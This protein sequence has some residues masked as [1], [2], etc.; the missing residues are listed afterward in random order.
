M[1]VVVIEP[2]RI[3]IR[4]VHFCLKVRW[5]DVALLSTGEGQKGLEVIE[6]ETPDLVILSSHLPDTD[7][8]DLIANIRRFSQVPLIV[9]TQ[10]QSDMDRV[11]FLEA[12]ADDCITT[13][14]S[15]IELLTKVRVLLR[16]TWGQ[17]F[18]FREQQPITIGDRVT[19]NTGTREV[20]VSDK[21]VRLTPT[22]FRVLLELVK[23]QGRVVSNEMLLERAWGAD[24]VSDVGF[25]KRYVYR[26]RQK[27]E[28]GTNKPIIISERGIGYRLLQSD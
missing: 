13:P 16:R 25:V 1:K 17:G 3:I 27:L 26:L 4:D 23:S 6:T 18:N 15:P 28:V 22:E 21:P 11:R 2:N 14:F 24:Y 8:G 10:E 7:T 20:M 19:I 12:G 5:P 9:L